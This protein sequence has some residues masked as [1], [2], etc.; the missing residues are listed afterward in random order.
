MV[1]IPPTTK[2][3]LTCLRPGKKQYCRIEQLP[4]LLKLWPSEID[5]YSY[6]GTLRV[7][8]LLRKALRAERRRAQAK[9]WAYDL[10]RH[11]G[12]LEAL[13]EERARLAMLES[14]LPWRGDAA[15]GLRGS[16]PTGT[17]HLPYAKKSE[18][19]DVSAGSSCR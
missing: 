6:P 18:A 15:L 3:R 9:H 10:N 14:A 4:R 13:K 11:L 12:L 19:P 17:L 8:A 16:R 7:V 5:D 2:P 1:F